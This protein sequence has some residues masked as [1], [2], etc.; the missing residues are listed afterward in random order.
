MA[1]LEKN[2]GLYLDYY[3][4]TMAQG[5]F[6]NG[7]KDTPASFDYL[8]RKAPFGG[9]FAV[10]A[11]LSDLLDI[12]EH[13]RF[14]KEDL[15]YLK[16]LGFK[17]E[18]LGYLKNFEFTA[19]IW[20]CNEGEVV[21]PFEPVLRVQ[22]NIIETQIIETLV[23]NILNFESLIATKAAR[24]KQAAGNRPVIDFGL[25][26]AQGLG[27]I[28]ASK[29]AV[30]GGADSTSNVYSAFKFD[31]QATGTQAH[32]WIQSY[33]NELTAFRDFAK[34]VPERCVLLVDTYD[35]LNSGVPNAIKVAKEL[36][37]SGHKLLAIR[38]DS[39]DLGQ[40]SKEARK[41]LDQANLAY[42]KIIA[43][44]QLNEFIIEDL[45]ARNC[46]IDAF[47]VGTSLITGQPDAALD[48]VYKLSMSDNK[49]RLKI[50]EDIEKIILPGVKKILR[51]LDEKGNFSADAIVL[52]HEQDIDT[53]YHL[54]KS[55]I[56][57]SAK[58]TKE[59]LLVRI[60]SKGRTTPQK[61]KIDEIAAKARERLARLPLEYK[62]LRHPSTYKV[63]I[64]EQLA[65]LRND[66]IAGIRKTYRATT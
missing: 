23:L 11:G 17:D 20:A 60:M 41:M 8:F 29:A 36:E 65:K 9:A 5:Y 15:A 19:D 48:G 10:F 64:S 53:I 12:L 7:R 22:G 25:R 30:T 6:L 61:K 33:D 47:G 52:E 37:R 51:C 55:G 62:Q 2:I 13:L 59:P 50:S 44:G 63:G 40:L 56:I 21:F 18:F 43:S 28:H 66:L 27:G 3:E 57:M 49:P 35:T 31:L 39:G 14:E 4:L 32:S 1:I 26:R 42:V 46:P 58:L 24:L 38:I 54:H 45:L 34:M 16:S